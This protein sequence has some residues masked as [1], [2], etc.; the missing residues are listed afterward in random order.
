MV[1]NEVKQSETLV[2]E[3]SME[4]CDLTQGKVDVPYTIKKIVTTDEELK[5]FL[6]TLGCYVGEKVTIIS[7]LKENMVLSIKDARYSIGEDLAKVIFVDLK[8]DV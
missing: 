8:E 3:A 7:Q 5:N 1:S 2:E 4:L 6:F